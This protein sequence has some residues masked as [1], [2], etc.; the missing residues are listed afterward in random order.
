[1]NT[2]AVLALFQKFHRELC[3]ALLVL[4]GL[5][6]GQ[7][8]ATLAGAVLRPDTSLQS[9][10]RP[11]LNSPSTQIL[12]R[13]LTQM[14]QQNM[15]DPSARGSRAATIKS[16]PTDKQVTTSTRKDLTLVGTLVSGANSTALVKI[17]KEIKLLHLEDPLPGGGH[18]ETIQRNRVIIRNRDKSTTELVVQENQSGKLRR[19][20]NASSA[21]GIQSAGNNRWQVSRAVA[22]AARTN[23][24]EQMRLA[25]LE[26]RI[27]NGR[28][29]GFIVSK[30]NPRSI[31][32]KMG[33]HRGDV[34]LKVN[35]M[36]IDSPEKALQILQQLREARQLT[37]DLERK[38]K[39]MTLS[40]EIN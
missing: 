35:N 38:D 1:L 10:R 17:G 20:A 12:D 8:A 2:S 19:N 36:P 9:A 7:L 3:L 37:V 34:I 21:T 5:A 31:L 26:P 4:F 14:L 16:A 13:D 25:Q 22:D 11:V 30:L 6:C 27:I 33:I 39:P 40:Y 28:T 15:F 32:A 18:V 24:A 23:I 29:D